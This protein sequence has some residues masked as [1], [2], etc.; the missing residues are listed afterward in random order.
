MPSVR[1]EARRFLA[2]AGRDLAAVQINLNLLIS[3][4]PVPREEE[5]EVALLTLPTLDQELLG[6]SLLLRFHLRAASD[7]LTRHKSRIGLGARG[8]AQRDPHMLELLKMIIGS[9]PELLAS[10][11]EK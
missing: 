4:M 3:K 9:D 8:K 1:S 5:F 10:R 11:E 7:V 2:K 6:V